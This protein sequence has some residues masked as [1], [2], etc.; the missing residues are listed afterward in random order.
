MNFE[1]L[2]DDELRDHLRLTLP[3][4]DGRNWQ[5]DE[6]MILQAI[7]ILEIKL[8]VRIRFMSSYA[9]NRYGESKNWRGGA[10]YSRDGWHRVTINQAY[11]EPESASKTL[12]HELAH[13]MQAERFVERTAR[14]LRDFHDEEYKLLDGEWGRS[15]QG[16]LLEIEANNI[17]SK[18]YLIY[19]LA[20][21]L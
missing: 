5:L 19:P 13:C 4:T 16:N 18:N 15:Y 21:E 12:W 9:T 20:K 2:A 17:A 10:H 11:K 14:P 8:P 7:D 3:P 1:P 6:R